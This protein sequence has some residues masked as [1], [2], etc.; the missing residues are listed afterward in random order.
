M[1]GS[2]IRRMGASGVTARVAIGDEMDTRT[3]VASSEHARSA[4]APDE[5]T[6]T[7]PAELRGPGWG[8]AKPREYTAPEL[9][10]RN[11][12]RPGAAPRDRSAVGGAQHSQLLPHRREGLDGAV[13]LGRLVAGGDLHPDPRLAAWDHREG[14]ADDVDP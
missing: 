8:G 4:R 7:P 11:G 9:K 3:R 12:F 10:R 1:A 5:V 13:D 6:K 14:E 2:S